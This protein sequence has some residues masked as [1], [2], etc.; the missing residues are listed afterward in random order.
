MRVLLLAD[1]LHM[2][3]AWKDIDLLV[4]ALDRTR[5]QPEVLT[6]RHTEHKF[7]DLGVP[8]HPDTRTLR[9][10]DDVLRK[11]DTELIHVFEPRAMPYAWMAAARR[12][13]PAIASYYNL[14]PL[15]NLP[16]IRWRVRRT[17]GR[18]ALLGMSKVIVPSAL[19]ERN[20]WYALSYPRNKVE[21]V[22]SGVPLDER[23][24]ERV[25]SR[26]ALGLPPNPL[27]TLV[28]PPTPEPGYEVVIEMLPRLRIKVPDVMLA[29]AGTG[30]IVTFLQKKASAQR[31]VPPVRWLGNRVDLPDVLH[32]SDVV[33]GVSAAEGVP[34]P[35]ILAAAAARPVIA[36]RVSGITELIEPTETGLLVT[37]GDSADLAIQLGRVLTQPGYAQRL[38][39]AAQRRVRERFSLDA[40]RDT[41]TTLY[42]ASIYA[43]R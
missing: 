17:L 42:E 25:P 27:I 6:L 37:V 39:A 20:L 12:G 7:D 40:Q 32:S 10:L 13:I 34:Q 16:P 31:P 19:H 4:T 15:L 18:A 3:D 41:M 1:D 14:D 24:P 29:V 38:G 2:H 9:A 5:I 30:P 23:P 26:E 35:L 11:H 28:V 21:V 36:T 43:T 22:H 33:I 8:R